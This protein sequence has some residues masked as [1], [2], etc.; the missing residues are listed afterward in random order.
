MSMDSV[1][2]GKMRLAIVVNT[3]R[4]VSLMRNGKITLK[5]SST[6]RSTFVF[7]SMQWSSQ[8]FIN[9]TRSVCQDANMTVTPNGSSAALKSLLK[10]RHVRM[11]SFLINS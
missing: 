10:A 6:S 1:S 9:G 5:M 7:F 8:R 11:L 2:W 4:W 3:I